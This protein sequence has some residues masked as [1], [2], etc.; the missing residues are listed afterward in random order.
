MRVHR[1]MSSV[2]VKC[3]SRKS[4]LTHEDDKLNEV[5]TKYK[6]G[7]VTDEEGSLVFGLIVFESS[8]NVLKYWTTM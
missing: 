5:V 8:L 2:R 4:L 6:P 3:S 1:R 7:F